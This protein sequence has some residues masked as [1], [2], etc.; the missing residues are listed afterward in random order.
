MRPC[1]ITRTFERKC[2]T[3]SNIGRY[4]LSFEVSNASVSNDAVAGKYPRGGFRCFHPLWN[5]LKKSK[6]GW[7]KEDAVYCIRAVG[8]AYPQSQVP[9]SF[10]CSPCKQPEAKECDQTGQC[11]D[12]EG[13]QCDGFQ[14]SGSGKHLNPYRRGVQ[15]ESLAGRRKT[16]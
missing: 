11:Q 1:C 9:V 13:A 7:A 10:T 14:I 3:A 4:T 6:M 15:C 2:S 12:N 16:C 5:T 8:L